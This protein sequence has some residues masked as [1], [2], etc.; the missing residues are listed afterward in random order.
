MFQDGGA[1]CYLS[2]VPMPAYMFFELIC[3]VFPYGLLELLTLNFENT[4]QSA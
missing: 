3:V 4:M 1:L 2:E